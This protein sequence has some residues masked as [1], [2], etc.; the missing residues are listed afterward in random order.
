MPSHP[1]THHEILTLISPFTHQGYHP[2]LAATDRLERR[3]VF[4]QVEHA[5]ETASDAQFSERLQLEN[6]DGSVFRLTR[7]LT[8]VLPSDEKLEAKLEMDG[9]DPADLL[10]CVQSVKADRQ[11]RFGPGFKIAKSYRLIR[12]AGTTRDG[13]PATQPVLTK[14][15]AH[16]GDLI[17]TATAPTIKADP[18]A[19]IEI[20]PMAGEYKAVPDDL[21][22]VLGWDWGLMQKRKDIWK[23]SLRLRGREPE[24]S[25]RAENKLDRMVDHLVQTF[26]EAPAKFHERL[27][28]ARWGVAFR[29]AVPLLI[30]IALIGAAAASANLPL[31][32]DSPIR[33]M[34]MNLPGFLMVFVFCMRKLPVIEVP[35]LP[36]RLKAP[37]W[38]EDAPLAASAP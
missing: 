27:T 29:R 14:M 23:S 24:R 6:R 25:R 8:C 2:D 19:H 12:L 30:S 28:G 5:F 17:V 35:P 36:R 26:T 11:F 21:L 10:A 13:A 16:I 37:A 15:S 32:E 1:L 33:M 22:A 18:E 9:T 20:Q 38:R 3:L 34:M 31:A 4:K 7:A